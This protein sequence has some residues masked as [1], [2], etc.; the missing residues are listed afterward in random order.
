[1]KK[2]EIQ[3]VEIIPCAF[4][5]KN[6]FITSLGKK[7]VAR[8]VFVL[9]RLAGGINGFGEASSS[10]AVPTA[11]QEA[12]MRELAGFKQQVEGMELE[13]AIQWAASGIPEDGHAASFAALETALYDAKARVKGVPL[14]RLFGKENQILETDVTVSAWPEATSR[15][16]V[17][18]ARKNGFRRFKIKVGVNWDQ[19]LKRVLAVHE[20]S[21]EA[22]L[23]LDGN[24]GF[25][26][27]G[28]IEFTGELARRNVKIECFEQPLPKASAWEEWSLVKNEIGVPLALDE[29]IT[30]AREALDFIRRGLVDMI[31]I[32]LA[33]SGVAETLRIMS[34]AGKN[35]I[36]LMMSCMA[37]SAAGLTASVHLAAG[38]GAFTYVDLDSFYLL[39]PDKKNAGGFSTKGAKLKINSRTKGSGVSLSFRARQRRVRPYNLV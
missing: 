18:A 5:Y 2:T 35:K 30:N 23:I 39:K 10:L 29:S 4:E 32:K 9:V 8:N 1:M 20:A 6:P 38:T 36:G 28:T 31:S 19:D 7:S 11:T 26:V 24:Q 15:K 33:K 25:S 13:E 34:L 27:P 17:L 14:A 16:F 22:A 21:P 12:M 37:E 3:E